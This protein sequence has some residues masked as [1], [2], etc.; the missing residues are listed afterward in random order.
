MR[1]SRARAVRQWTIMAI[2]KYY[3]G[4]VLTDTVS[5]SYEDYAAFFYAHGLEML[6]KAYIIGNR[7]S[8]YRSLSFN[9]AKAELNE[10]AKHFGHN[11]KKLIEELIRKSVLPAGFLDH[12]HYHSTIN[13]VDLTNL[14]MLNT[15]KAVYIE[16]RYPVVEPDY[17]RYYKEKVRNNPKAI[18]KR[19]PEIIK[20][21]HEL[22]RFIIK[23]FRLIL[24]SIERDF[25]LT[26]SR[27]KFSSDINDKD[28]ERF[29]NLFFK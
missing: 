24:T 6:C 21:S 10:I 3:L 16:A 4:F 11:L 13:E 20:Y 5:R 12:I 1:M 29:S 15:L 18:N 9:A 26:F 27:D 8:L 7:Y 25:K 23:L 2:D 28:W 17:K 14:D 22:E 19:Y